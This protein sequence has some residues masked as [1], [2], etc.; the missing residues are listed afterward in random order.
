VYKNRPVL[1]KPKDPAY[2]R[3]PLQND[4]WREIADSMKMGAEEC[5]NKM[6]SLL[7]SC[8]REKAKTTTIHQSFCIVHSFAD[9]LNSS[10]ILNLLFFCAFAF[11][12]NDVF[13]VSIHFPT[14]N[15]YTQK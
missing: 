10:S 3:K 1:W 12:T 8:R 5:K 11:Y 9:T 7:A 2:Y 6:I 4:A 15:T 13:V 14:V